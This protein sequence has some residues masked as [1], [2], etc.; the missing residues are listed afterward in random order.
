MLDGPHGPACDDGDADEEH[1][2][3]GSEA[4]HHPGLCALRDAEDDGDEER[5]EQ[6]GAEV[7]Q[8]A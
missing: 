8:H 6:D 3:V 5:E 2:A 1:E 4:D 7:S